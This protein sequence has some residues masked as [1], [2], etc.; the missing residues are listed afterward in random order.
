MKNLICLLKCRIIGYYN[1]FT[2]GKCGLHLYYTGCDCEE[3]ADY[4]EMEFH[5]FINKANRGEFKE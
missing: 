5:K 2:T 3:C 4:Y 1:K